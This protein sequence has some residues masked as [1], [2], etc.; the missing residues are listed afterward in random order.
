LV[1]LAQHVLFSEK[2]TEYCIF[3]AEKNW[4]SCYEI[5]FN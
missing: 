1:G 5:V 4:S 2:L 3:T